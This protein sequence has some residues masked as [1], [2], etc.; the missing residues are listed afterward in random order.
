MVMMLG[1]KEAV[2]QRGCR[3]IRPTAVRGRQG[4]H[5]ERGAA[6]DSSKKVSDI[7]LFCTNRICKVSLHAASQNAYFSR[8]P[9][10]HPEFSCSFERLRPSPQRK[11]IRK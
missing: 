4:H 5:T 7:D 9:L 10:T 6:P 3:K 1:K 8:F 11:C 2:S